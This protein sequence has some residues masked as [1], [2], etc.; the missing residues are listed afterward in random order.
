MAKVETFETEFAGKKLIIKTG[1]LAQQANGSCTVQ[2]GDTMVLATAV[3]NLE[4]K[5]GTDYFPLMVEY[6][7][8]MYAGG[9]IKGSRFIKRETRPSDEAILV[10]RM[11]DRGLRP[12][13]DQSMRNDV[14]VV[15][16]VLS[17]DAE[18]DPDIPAVIAASCALH[19]SDIPFNG[20]VTGI[21]VGQINGEWVINPTFMAR[22][23][24]VLDL[25]FTAGEDKVLM[26]EAGAQEVDEKTIR[27]AF[28]F[29][30][31][32]GRKIVKFLNEIREKVGKEKIAIAKKAEEDL[33]ENQKMSAAEFEKLQTE[34]RDFIIS[35]LD[36]YLFNIPKGS[37][38]E[39]K[40]T[41]H[42]LQ[43]KLEEFLVGKQVSK[44]KRKKIMEL[45]SAIVEE[46]ITKAILEKKKRI[47]GR[48][49]DALRP[50]SCEVGVLPRTHGSA[51]FNR[52]ETQVLSTITL[53][54]PGDEQTIE[55]MGAS[56]KKRFMHHYNFPPYSTGEAA[57]FRSTGRREIGHGALAEKALLPVIPAREDF[58]YTIRVVSEVLSSN[59]SS[60][61]ASTCGSTLALMDAGVPIKKPVAGI[62]IGIASNEKGE[63]EI[64]T[65]IQDLEDGEG[66]MDFKIAGTRDGIT[67]IQM[68][69]KTD[70]LNLKIIEK[71]LAQGKSARISLLDEI[72]KTI[73][74]PRKELS[75]FAPRIEMVRINPEKIRDLIG[76]GG[77][78]INAI[79]DE[80]GVAIDIEDDGLVMITSVSPDGMKKALEKIAAITREAELGQIYVGTV[81]RL[82]EC[83]AIVEIFPGTD[84]MVHISEITDKER[85]NDI[86]KYLKEGQ[87][88]KVKVIRIDAENGKIGLSMKR[89]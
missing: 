41:L 3:I 1:N 47:D 16:T 67:A 45:F 30:L 18:N 38:K 85:V 8:K 14:Q 9:R 77:K 66:G 19:I 70:G 23:K 44:D 59:G 29:G 65:D 25:A 26:V 35:K 56:G 89:I 83:G 20:P 15:I 88:V 62:A 53:G 7:E 64:L 48:P 69:T 57:P 36:E 81:T 28:E 27:D 31:K 4:P 78:V 17:V 43:D 84:G 24:S 80:T 2:Y 5:E 74:E 68:D 46:Q 82:L 86:R 11:I 34:G 32:H 42:I 58:P 55:G 60:S 63:F 39:R 22:E 40:Q 10:A 75:Q 37:K 6:S 33:D 76:P 71:A 21:R 79:I 73:P 72:A 51:I 61:M 52:G 54:A 13:F 49:L 12:L 87:Q 50:I